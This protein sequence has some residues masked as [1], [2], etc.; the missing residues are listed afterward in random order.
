MPW[1]PEI[2]GIHCHPIRSNGVRFNPNHVKVEPQ[3]RWGTGPCHLPEQG[4]SHTCRH[5]RIQVG[6]GTDKRP[7]RVPQDLVDVDQPCPDVPKPSCCSHPISTHHST[8]HKPWEQPEAA[9]TDKTHTSHLLPPLHAL[10]SQLQESFGGS[11]QPPHYKACD[12]PGSLLAGVTF[13]GLAPRVFPTFG[14]TCPFPG[15]TAPLC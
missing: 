12:G 9:A 8:T 7:L 15:V 10:S 11:R 6:F 1:A 3:W 14:R 4:H 2:F 13:C 5:Q